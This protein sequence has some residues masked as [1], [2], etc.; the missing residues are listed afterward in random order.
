M[1]GAPGSGDPKEAEGGSVSSRGSKQ[2][3]PRW[4]A[5]G[6][7]AEMYLGLTPSRRPQACG[8]CEPCDAGIACG[9]VSKELLVE[10]DQ[11]GHWSPARW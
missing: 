3:G 9:S 1:G 10:C 2:A 4:S 11:H 7:P 5:R 6:P 8:G